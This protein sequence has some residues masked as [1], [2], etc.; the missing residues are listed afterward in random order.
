MSGFTRRDFSKT[1]AVT[2]LVVGTAG[3]TGLGL[4]LN[5]TGVQAFELEHDGSVKV[6]FGYGKRF[7]MKIIDT[8]LCKKGSKEVENKKDRASLFKAHG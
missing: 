5:G 4:M 1:I 7:E 3:L 2:T 8:L 6:W